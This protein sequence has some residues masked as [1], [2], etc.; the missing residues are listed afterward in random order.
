MERARFRAFVLAVALDLVL[1]AQLV[2]AAGAGRAASSSAPIEAPGAAALATQGETTAPVALRPR[3]P[4]PAP[5]ARRDGSGREHF[6]VEPPP[7][8]AATSQAG[9]RRMLAGRGVQFEP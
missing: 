2:G 7:S 4:P 6:V 5:S 1:A 9:L 3:A 8:V